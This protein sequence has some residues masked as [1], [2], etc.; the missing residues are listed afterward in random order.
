[1]F[2]IHFGNHPFPEFYR[3]CMWIV[4]TKDLYTLFDPKKENGSQ[5]FPQVLPVCR[6]KIKRINILIFFRRVFCI[7]NGS[8]RP[9]AE[10]IR[11]FFYIGMIWRALE[12][13]VHGQIN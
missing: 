13:D 11:M 8:I 9:L 2:T 1:M 3:F 5:F 7:L 10:P 12:S 6:L 4:Y